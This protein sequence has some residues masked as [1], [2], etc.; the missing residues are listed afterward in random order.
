MINSKTAVDFKHFIRDFTVAVTVPIRP[1]GE[2]KLAQ[3]ILLNAMRDV[4]K[5]SNETEAMRAYFWLKDDQGGGPIDLYTALW[6]AHLGDCCQ[7]LNN[8]RYVIDNPEVGK[9]V[10]AYWQKGS[11]WGLESG[12]KASRS[13]ALK[14]RRQNVCSGD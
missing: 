7:L 14:W 6:W 12:I 8:I 1:T 10:Y 4:L 11:L 3:A 2:Q 9:K 5:G 13:E